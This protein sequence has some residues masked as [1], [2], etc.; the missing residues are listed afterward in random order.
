MQLFT[1]GLWKLNPDGS[2]QAPQQQ[3]YDNTD[4]VSFAR[5]WTGF[6]TQPERGNI[7]N[8]QGTVWTTNV[9][10]PMRI[11][12]QWRDRAPKT[13]L[14]GGYLGDGYPLCDELPARPFLARG[15]RYVFTGNLSM[16]ARWGWG[17]YGASAAAALPRQRL[18][19]GLSR[20]AAAAAAAGWQAAE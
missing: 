8:Q 3:S 9:I 12:P 17:Q 10:D 4:I 1:I 7:E 18:E 19:G 5:V 14:N 20:S 2:E 11:R 6:D 13:Q 16:Y 15:A